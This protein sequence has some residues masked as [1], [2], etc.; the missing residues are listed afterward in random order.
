MVSKT[1]LNMAMVMDTVMDTV[2]EL[3]VKLIMM[4]LNQKGWRKNI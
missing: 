4:K 1:K 2:M 3:M